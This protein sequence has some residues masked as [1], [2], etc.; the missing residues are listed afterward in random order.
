MLGWYKALK[1]LEHKPELLE[2]AKS[3]I[4]FNNLKSG[5]EKN[6]I[7]F[8]TLRRKKI[9]IFYQYH[10]SICL[11]T[12]EHTNLY[13]SYKHTTQG[14]RGCQCLEENLCECLITIRQQFV[15]IVPSF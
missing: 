13:L 8:T 12:L 6:L 3:F 2:V 7:I 5:G 1:N 4:Q 15:V 14:I 9:K 11:T 10:M